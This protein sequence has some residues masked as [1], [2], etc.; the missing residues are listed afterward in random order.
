MKVNGTA[1]LIFFV[2]L[3]AFMG[4]AVVWVNEQVG[5]QMAMGLGISAFIVM[6]VF[7]Q[8]ILGNIQVQSILTSL[9][10]YDKNQAAVEGKRAQIQ[11]ENAKAMRDVTKVESKISEAQYRMM[12]DTAKRMAGYL[13]EAEVEDVKRQMLALHGPTS[14]NKD[15][16]L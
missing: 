3:L 12:L 8:Q 10:E 13:S 7:G 6:I 2:I 16:E 11:I 5:W 4:Y 14:S 15:F 9:V 1:F